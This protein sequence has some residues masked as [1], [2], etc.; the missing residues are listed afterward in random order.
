MNQRGAMAGDSQ[1]GRCAMSMSA[2]AMN[3]TASVSE[4]LARVAMQHDAAATT[5]AAT[6]SVTSTLASGRRRRAA[7][8]SPIH[9]PP[10]AASRIAIHCAS[11]SSPMSRCGLRRV[12]RAP[13]ASAKHAERGRR[14]ARRRDDERAGR[15]GHGFPLYLAA[16]A[17]GRSHPPEARRRGAR[18]GRDSQ[19]SSPASPTARGRTIRSRRC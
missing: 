2:C 18:R 15:V 12:E 13:G 9:V 1:P 11:R 3:A 7:T 10:V 14:S 8:A 6:P 17:R 5:T 4:R 19:R 16:H